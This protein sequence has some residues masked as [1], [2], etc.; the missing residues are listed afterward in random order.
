MNESTLT[1]LIGVTGVTHAQETC[2]RNLHGIERSSIRF[3][4]QKLSDT[5]DQSNRT[6]LVTCIGASFWYKFLAR[7]SQL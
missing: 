7:V 6:I 5:A 1:M 3:R 4:Y 2:T